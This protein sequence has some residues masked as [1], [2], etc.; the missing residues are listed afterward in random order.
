MFHLRKSGTEGLQGGAG[1]SLDPVGN[2]EHF[3]FIFSQWEDLKKWFYW[4]AGGESTGC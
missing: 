2:R 4:L 1:R 3:I